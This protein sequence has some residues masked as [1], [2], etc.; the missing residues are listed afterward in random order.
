MKRDI[1]PSRAAHAVV[2]E[3]LAEL[4]GCRPR[5]LGTL[6]AVVDVDELDAFGD[7]RF[8]RTDGEVESLEFRYCGYSMELFSDRTLYVKQ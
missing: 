4:E 3:T 7:S 8:D 5:D 6:E 2:K 1:P